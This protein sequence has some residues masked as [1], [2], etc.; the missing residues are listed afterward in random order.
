MANG[1]SGQGGRRAFMTAGV[2]GGLAVLGSGATASGTTQQDAGP[3]QS[4]LPVREHR[5]K[6]ATLRA[7][8]RQNAGGDIYEILHDDVEWKIVNGRTYVSKAEFLAE[9]SAPIMDRLATTLVMTISD[10]WT[11]GDTVI[12]RFEG[13]ST[14]T[15][16]VAYHNEYCWVWEMRGGLVTRCYA[17]LDMMAVRELVDRI[18]LG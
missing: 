12:I 11:D 17:F 8:K 1:T 9:G 3:G 18:D 16:G 6:A 4:D 14:A 2:G 7:F 15:D 10:L 13:D 5:N